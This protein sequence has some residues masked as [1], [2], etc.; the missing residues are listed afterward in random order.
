MSLPTEERFERYIDKKL[1]EHGYQSTSHCKYD[2]NQY[3]VQE[4]LINFIKSTQ[5][6]T[7]DKLNTLFG[8][9]TDKQIS[10]VVNDEISN[11]GLIDVLR[12]GI[13]FRGSSFDMV[14]FKPKSGLNPE[15]HTKY[16]QNSFVSIRQLFYSNKNIS[17]IDMVLFLNGIP[18]ITMELKNQLTGQNFKNAESQYKER[19]I[20]GEPLLQF[21][22]CL[23]HFCVDNNKVSMTTHLNNEQTKFL[24]YNKDIEN[25]PVD[26]SYRTEYL[27][28]EILAP[29]SILD[30]IEN[31]VIAREE[32][33][34]VW[35]DKEGK[36]T[37][38]KIRVLIFPRYH[39]L[40][41]IRKLI[42]QI[43]DEGIGHNYLI[44]HT[45]GS[46]KS[47]SIGWLSHTLTSLYRTERD[48]KRIF[49]T[50][51]VVSDRKVLDKQ[52][53]KTI[54]DLQQTEGVVRS[55]DINSN[56]LKEF[57]EKGKDIIITTIQ[58][59][60][61]ISKSISQ[62]EGKTF[63]VIIDEVHSSQSG[64]TS[65]HLKKSLSKDE[66][67][68]IDFEDVIISSIK[69]RGRQPHISF[70]GFTGTPKNKTLELFGRKNCEGNF[71][72]F[73]LY[74]M[75]QSIHEGFTLDVLRHYASYKRYF[76]LIQTSSEDKKLPQSRAMKQI[77]D[78]VDSHEKIIGQKVAIIL[79]HF[80]IKSSKKINNQARGMVVLRSR[81]HCVLFFKEF[82]SQMKER[83]LPY[84]C[85]VGF[86]GIVNLK[87]KEYTENSL[88]KNNGMEGNDIP[89]GLRDPRFRIL[90]VANKFQTGFNEPHMHSMYIDKKLSAVQCVQT[91][92]RLNRSTNGKTDT[93]VLDFINEAEEI[94]KSFEPYYNSATLKEETDP[95][96]LHELQSAIKEYE[97]FSDKHIE[98]F[99][100]EFYKVKESDEKLH[101]IIDEVVDNW[102]KLLT[103]EEKNEFKSLIREFCSLY[104]YVS[105]IAIL[106]ENSHEKLYIFLKFL[107]K[108]IPK[109]ESEKVDILDSIS[110]DSF[111]IQMLGESQLS[112]KNRNGETKP[113]SKMPKT[114]TNEENKDS[115]SEII[116]KLNELHGIK[117]TEDDKVEL[118]KLSQR[119]KGNDDLENVMKANNTESDIKD[120]FTR[121]YEKEVTSI[122]RIKKDLD[123]YRKIKDSKVEQMVQEWLYKE[124][125]EGLQTAN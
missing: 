38:E 93:F 30:I 97:I 56:Q 17:S 122:Y 114:S 35:N 124:C 49:D 12:K 6:E 85:L 95:K 113:I 62:F 101:P 96:R 14:Y 83:E 15:H 20:A 46:G 51:I 16:E 121:L 82:V 61:F 43:K 58:K 21:K 53:Q 91:L 4:E 68:N 1:T 59:F 2:K 31:F 50:I 54:K 3:Q 108:K 40:D 24:P 100:K 81:K 34:S 18:M 28:N 41:V 44:Q 48:T 10:K 99:C 65:K 52:L 70:F 5:K 63:A 110:L 94:E 13:S 22:R 69:S 116:K 76:K 73:H 55:V 104:S 9:A 87:G 75:K 7:Y 64:E 45:T 86:S 80:S 19:N 123:L 106:T 84:S 39:Q 66:E 23:V 107:Y 125:K 37:Y 98:D 77:I 27:W 32:L 47:L 25:P 92:S 79:D 29:D 102:K 78:Y 33:K 120:E 105:Q 71:V 36:V 88:N 89:S 90:I 119:I 109:R 72:P 26:E 8:D 111:R 74:S 57:L 42:D 103:E 67:G 115:L 112:P 11:R 60:P 117:F 118:E